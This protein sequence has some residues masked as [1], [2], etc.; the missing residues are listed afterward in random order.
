[1]NDAESGIVDVLRALIERRKLK[2]KSVAEAAGIPYRT[3]QNYL[4]KSNKMPLAAYLDVC[5]VIGIPPDYPITRRFKI[6]HH[7]LQQ[8]LIDAAGPLLNAVDV[9]EDSAMW[10]RSVV[11][12]HDEKHV[13]RIAGFLA[14]MINGRYDLIREAELGEPGEVGQ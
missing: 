1:M 11:G 3:L 12:D 4:A 8:A 2:I 14:A 9:D 7:A 6:D 10:I 5:S 13:R